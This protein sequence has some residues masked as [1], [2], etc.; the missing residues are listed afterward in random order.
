MQHQTITPDKMNLRQLQANSNV[1]KT[2]IQ[3]SEGNNL[4]YFI[5]M[6]NWS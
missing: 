2:H 1:Y 6:V 3:H 5:L 4:L